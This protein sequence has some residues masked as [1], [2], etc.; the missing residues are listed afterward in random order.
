MIY[1]EKM[2]EE[3]GSP[4]QAE[5][6]ALQQMSGNGSKLHHDNEDEDEAKEVGQRRRIV[7]RKNTL[8]PHH[9]PPH[10]YQS[11]KA[12]A[13]QAGNRKGSSTLLRRFDAVNSRTS[14]D[15]DLENMVKGVSSVSGSQVQDP[16]NVCSPRFDKASGAEGGQS[17]T[18]KRLTYGG[19]WLQKKC[20]WCL[21]RLRNWRNGSSA[22]RPRRDSILS[23][24]SLEERRQYWGPLIASKGGAA[25]AKPLCS[26]FKA[27]GHVTSACLWHACRAVTFGSLLIIMGI[28]MAVLG[29]SS[30]YSHYFCFHKL[31]ILKKVPRAH[32]TRS[33]EQPQ[34]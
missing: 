6:L 3:P 8:L 14:Q 4:A 10:Y 18:K 1:V 7:I 12:S 28:T 31:D 21:H 11:R 15:L 29:K 16:D 19:Q 20:W 32:I 24:D 26:K 13:G 27:E 17:S 22:T 25:A 9:Q 30:Q 34:D 2:E 5:R 23:N 33:W